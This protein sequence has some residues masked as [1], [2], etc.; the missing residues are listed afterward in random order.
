MLKEKFSN[1]KENGKLT[2]EF[3][4]KIKTLKALK[5]FEMNQTT[6]SY[7]ELFEN[8][9]EKIKNKD[10]TKEDFDKLQL[11]FYKKERELE[12]VYSTKV[13]MENEIKNGNLC[14]KDEYEVLSFSIFHYAKTLIN[15]ID[16]KPN[17]E[18]QKNYELMS[19]VYNYIRNFGYIC[20]AN[21]VSNVMLECQDL[22]NK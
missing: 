20:V 10:F 3:E 2:E 8:E 16:L 18:I 11:N 6:E 22:L 4:N 19:T 21:A 7:I 13:H 5:S 1:L 15:D 12:F 17:E 9:T 14:I